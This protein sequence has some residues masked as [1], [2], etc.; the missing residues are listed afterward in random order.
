MVFIHVFYT[1]YEHQYEIKNS[2]DLELTFPICQ[3]I[4]RETINCSDRNHRNTNND[5]PVR[6]TVGIYYSIVHYT[7]ISCAYSRKREREKRL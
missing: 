2:I 4:I 7:I 1:K 3:L 6:D 5:S